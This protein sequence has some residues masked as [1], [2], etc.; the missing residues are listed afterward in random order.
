MVR[1]TK[2]NT[3][4]TVVRRQQLQGREDTPVMHIEARHKQ[5]EARAHDVVE[6][7]LLEVGLRANILQ[8]K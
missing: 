1:E 6:N 8:E 4:S 5:A 7:V 2:S 3:V